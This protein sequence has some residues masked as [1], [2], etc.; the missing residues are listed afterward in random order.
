M[1]PWGRGED[2]SLWTLFADGISDCAV[3]LQDCIGA[4]CIG[5]EATFLF[6]TPTRK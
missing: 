2:G 1:G 5:D 4:D 6:G 3:S